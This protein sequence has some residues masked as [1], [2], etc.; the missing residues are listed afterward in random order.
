MTATR[1]IMAIV[2]LAGLCGCTNNDRSPTV[3][4]RPAETGNAMNDVE[5]AL[6]SGMDAISNIDIQELSA[7]PSP[8]NRYVDYYALVIVWGC[9]VLDVGPICP[10]VNWDGSLSISGPAVIDSVVPVD[11][12][13]K[14]DAIPNGVAETSIHWK[15]TTRSDFDGLALRIAHDR[16]IAHAAEPV[17][18]LTTPLFSFELSLSEVVH[19]SRTFS[20]D[21]VNSVSIRAHRIQQSIC[22]QGQFVGSL[23][24]KHLTDNAGMLSGQWVADCGDNVGKFMGSFWTVSDGSRQFD[25]AIYRA[26]SDTAIGH[27]A[28]KWH[29]DGFIRGQ[30]TCLKFG[31]IGE[32]SGGFG[33][34]QP[35]GR[36][37]TAKLTG[38]WEFDCAAFNS[39]HWQEN[40]D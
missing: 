29:P 8:D 21:E 2:L 7:S 33:P 25:G 22:G 10:E 28:G 17:F 9:Q 20:I 15:S 19:Y 38:N 35:A 14:G 6:Q 4:N 23:I 18:A 30:L 12:D 13:E 36:L 11:Q 40:S 1:M 16:T 34:M 26:G 32:M 37:Y 27:F 31:A 39:P 3:S 5:I 24:K